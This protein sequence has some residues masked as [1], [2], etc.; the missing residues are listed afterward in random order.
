MAFF[1]ISLHILH[2]IHIFGPIRFPVTSRDGGFLTVATSA[3]G[4][5]YDC[6]AG[7]HQGMRLS[8]A[9]HKE[10]YLDTDFLLD[11]SGPATL[12]LPHRRTLTDGTSVSWNE[13]E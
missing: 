13:T 9:H 3:R 8:L 7:E 1:A 11:V 4:G 6:G 12:S 5:N 2:S 10:R